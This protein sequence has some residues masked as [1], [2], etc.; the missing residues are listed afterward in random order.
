M[1]LAIAKNEKHRLISEQ[2]TDQKKAITLGDRINWWKRDFR[3]CFNE[4]L[5]LEISKIKAK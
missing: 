2:E 5:Y 1:N 4:K 3:G